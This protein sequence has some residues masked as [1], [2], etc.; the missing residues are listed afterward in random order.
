M[1]KKPERCFLL[2]VMTLLKSAVGLQRFT[3]DEQEKCQSLKCSNGWMLKAQPGVSYSPWPEP[4]FSGP[5]W[6]SV[7]TRAHNM[8]GS[9]S[10]APWLQRTDTERERREED[11]VR[12]WII[13]T[14]TTNRMS[15]FVYILGIF[16]DKTHF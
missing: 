14:Y 6:H 9:R 7:G 10:V 4:E 1:N 11:S 13:S 15:I 5:G 12:S 16:E 8:A 2:Y 3:F